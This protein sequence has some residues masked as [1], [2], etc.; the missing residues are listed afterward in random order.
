MVTAGTAPSNNST[1]NPGQDP[2][3][4]FV[5]ARAQ[6]VGGPPAEVALEGFA[7]GLGKALALNSE[8]IINESSV[9]LVALKSVEGDPESSVVTLDID[10][11]DY[12]KGENVMGYF[13]QLSLSNEQDGGKDL[14]DDIN[15]ALSGITTTGCH[16]ITLQSGGFDCTA[17]IDGEPYST[18]SNVT[19]DEVRESSLV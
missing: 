3:S 12:G 14:A 9:A 19:I 17:C 5:R 13:L 16:C 7:V 2:A 1:S 4:W 18:I 11:E 15:S 10:V 6:L 8:G